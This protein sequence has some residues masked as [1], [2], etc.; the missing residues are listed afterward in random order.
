MIGVSPRER[1]RLKRV[2][3]SANIENLKL[4]VDGIMYI[5][6]FT[7]GDLASHF[8]IGLEM[9]FVMWQHIALMIIGNEIVLK[10]YIYIRQHY[11]RMRL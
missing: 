4:R 10:I 6:K 8:F 1:L 3:Q 9:A 2:D 5:I 7:I 11:L